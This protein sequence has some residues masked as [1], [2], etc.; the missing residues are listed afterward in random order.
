MQM[1]KKLDVNKATLANIFLET[2]AL[3]EFLADPVFTDERGFSDLAS[4][5][6]DEVYGKPVKSDFANISAMCWSYTP[7]QNVLLKLLQDRGHYF[8]ETG[9][10]RTCPDQQLQ[11]MVKATSLITCPD[12]QA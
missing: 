10:P 5:V 7:K 6:I 1:L 4:D 12:R 9:I 3:R 2:K 11:G 8:Q